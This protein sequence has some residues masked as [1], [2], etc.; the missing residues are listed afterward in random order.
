MNNKIYW[1][2]YKGLE[3]E[4]LTLTEFIHIDDDQLNI[5]SMHIADLLTRTVV[6]IESISKRLYQDNGG[7]ETDHKK[8]YFDNVCIRY[9]NSLWNLESKVVVVTSPLLFLKKPKNTVL[10]PLKDAMNFKT[11]Q[12]DWNIAYQNVKHNRVEQLREGKVK[13]LLHAL[14]ALYV[15]NLY[16]R[17]DTYPMGTN[18]NISA[19]DQSFGSSLFSVSI[20]P[21]QSGVNVEGTYL[22]QENYDQCIYLV[23]NEPKTKQNAIDKMTPVSNKLMETRFELTRALVEKETK[24][25]GCIPSQ[26]K[27]KDIYNSIKMDESI[28][29]KVCRPHL[30][31]L[32]Q[33]LNSLEYQAVLNKQQY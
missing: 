8:M 19:I 24:E 17:G 21:V 3:R 22:K 33:A 7:T 23:E 31:E 1:Q 9:L 18:P 2:L 5:Y 6:E 26:E 27:I 15:L 30:L 11:N 13:Y 4:F 20:H 29:D 32:T 25:I 12:V 10:T 14:A 28:K 16:H